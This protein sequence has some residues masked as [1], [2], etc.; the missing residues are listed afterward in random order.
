MEKLPWIW[1]FWY[2]LPILIRLALEIFEVF[3][4]QIRQVYGQCLS[5]Y[6]LMCSLRC[7]VI[8][9]NPF[10]FHFYF[11]FVFCLFLGFILFSFW[12]LGL[13]GLLLIVIK[14]FISY[15]TCVN[16]ADEFGVK[17]NLNPVQISEKNV[18][19]K[20]YVLFAWVDQ[21]CQDPW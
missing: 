7:N 19:L 20:F 18:L 9:L 17:R 6:V 2:T 8:Q 5:D 13:Q 21:I 14:T 15:L 4:S 1:R 11:V 16:P 12:F 10:S 3:S